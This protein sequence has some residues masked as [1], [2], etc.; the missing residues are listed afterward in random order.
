[1]ISGALPWMRSVVAVIDRK[2]R[3]GRKIDDGVEL[4]SVHEEVRELGSALPMRQGISSAEHKAVRGVEQRRSVLRV[5][6][7]R[8]LRKIVFA[9][10]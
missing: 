1:M 5:Q 2:G 10:Y 4:P 3:A 7:E 8:I 9:G 6:I